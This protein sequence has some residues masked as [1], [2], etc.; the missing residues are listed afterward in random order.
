MAL[1][2]LDQAIY[3]LDRQIEIEVFIRGVPLASGLSDVPDTPNLLG[4]SIGFDTEQLPPT[5]TLTV[6][7]IAIHH[8]QIERGD[9]VEINAGFNG[10]LE[11]IFTGHV[12]R[13]TH[14]VANDTIECV[15]RTAVLTRPWRSPDDPKSW[16]AQTAVSAIEDILDDLTPAFAPAEI[17]D[18]VWGTAA[19]VAHG[20]TTD[21]FTIGYVVP[22]RMDSAAPS[23]MI[24]KI[25]DV[26]GYRV[27]E[28]KSGTLRIRPLLE[29]P[30]PAGYRIYG[31]QGVGEIANATISFDDA[32]IDSNPVLGN[33]AANARRAQGFTP[34]ADGNAIRMT[35][36][37]RKVGAPTDR[38]W[39]RIEEDDGAGEPNG[40]VLGGGDTI[41]GSILA[42]GSST[43][44]DIV[45]TTETRLV[46]GRVYHLVV[47]RGGGLDAVNYYEVGADTSAGYAGGIANVY[48]S[49]GGTWGA[50]GGDLA[51]EIEHVV[52][53]TL[54]LLGIADDED[55]DQI[56]KEVI[57]RGA[58]VPST[59]PASGDD[60]GGDE[61]QVQ[62]TA[63][64]HTD[65]NDLVEGD[66][67]L[68]SMVYTN[69]LIETVE[70]ADEVAARLIDKYHRVLQ[71]IE[72][73]VPFD[74][75]IDLGSTVEIRDQGTAPNYAGEVTG[76][77][78]NWWV[79]SYQ[80]SL[81]PDGATTSISLYGG[82]QSGSASE[83]N[84]QA[85][86]YWLIEREL[87][88]NAVQAVVTFFD[89][90]IDADGWIVNYHWVDDYLGGATDEEGESLR[91]ITIAYNPGTDASINM[92]LTVT[93]N[94]GNTH[95]VTKSVDVSTNN[96]EIYTPT[97]V[98]AGG[99]TCMATFD[100]G[101]S[102]AD[103]ATPSGV[104][105]KCAVGYNNEP[106]DP[107]VCFYG[108]DDGHIYRSIDSMASLVEVVG[109]ALTTNASGVGEI[110][111]IRSNRFTP[112]R[113]WACCDNGRILRSDDFG[114]T[115]Y[116][117]HDLIF[118]PG[119][120]SGYTAG[121]R[122][123]APDPELVAAGSTAAH[124]VT[125]TP[126]MGIEVSDPDVNRIWIWGGRGNE[127]E[128]WFHTHYLRDHPALWHSEIADVA[129]G[130]AADGSVASSTGNIAD[131]VADIVVSHRTAG[132]L[133]LCFTGRNPVFMYAKPKYYPATQGEWA[134][135]GGTPAVDGVS[136]AGNNA[137]MHLFG[138]VMDNKNFYRSQEGYGVWEELVGVLPGTGANRPHDLLNISAWK[139]IYI[140]AMD[141]GIAKSIDYGETWAFFRGA[142][143]GDIVAWPGGGGDI[144]YDCDIIYRRP[145]RFDIM[146]IVRDASG[147][148]AGNNLAVR[149]GLGGWADQ[150]A[151][152]T[153]YSTDPHR[154]W[155]FPQIDDQTLFF[156]RYTSALVG[157][158]E[159]LYRSTD[160]GGAWANVL[161]RCGT[162][163]RGPDG[164]IWASWESHAAGHAAGKHFP[165]VIAYSD[166]D[167]ATWTDAYT[168]PRNSGGNNISYFNIAVDPN[169]NRRVMAAGHLIANNLRILVTE[170][171]HLG[172]GATWSEV[173]P[174]GLGTYEG[175]SAVP[176]HHQPL[177]LAGENGRWLAGVQS[178]AAQQ[179]EIW[180][181]DNNG[182]TWTKTY[183]D[184]SLGNT[185]GFSDAFRMGNILFFGGSMVGA[186]VRS[187]G[188]VSFNNGAD[189]EALTA[190]AERQQG[191]VFDP[192]FSLLIGNQDTTGDNRLKFMLPPRPGYQ[193]N[194]GI[195]GGLDA[196]MPWATAVLVGN[197]LAVQGTV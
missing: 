37:L 14:D 165:H 194:S 64:R 67:R 8:V 78:G 32:N 21:D 61:T 5:A 103:I 157:H 41:A 185:W 175:A 140:V 60:P 36:W 110:T 197:A 88:G 85:D 2:P 72:I 179:R 121:S 99:T 190:D 45:V 138:M 158:S 130:D 22:A 124:L 20:D 131:T 127:P 101:V 50:G 28:Q 133:G 82:D 38:V 193:W 147:G 44:V 139:D 4:V 54:R 132:D 115:W 3:A 151:I 117:Y 129:H 150:G 46:S 109:P 113:W 123:H 24:R 125:P 81:T 98:C 71:S 87:V 134:D 42:V 171:A 154:L 107:P 178:A 74:P 114:A 195:A 29:A 59:T 156:V 118:G 89:A 31:T 170:D 62:I 180:I 160:L 128:S 58:T 102:W 12:K 97:L 192:R 80:H 116:V 40:T 23:D 30:A 120:P 122:R 34:T 18:I 191:F 47:G 73:E 95:S 112:A 10:H 164:R 94:D 146:A 105:K 142:G 183:T 177:L 16:T 27:Y 51:F 63:Q 161:A 136:V 153:G 68:Y 6:A 188:L 184:S 77:L 93:D 172:A 96:E 9:T 17:D 56:K 149:Q 168:D 65:S 163:T 174:T 76:L 25:A 13:R 181:S 57:V 33:V 169:N 35:F 144:G 137:K 52:F 106:D 186:A 166:D 108:T 145:R 26:Y 90:S 92:T 79:R 100:G 48:D 7:D 70:T 43:Q 15:G 196:A 11:R 176:K 104:A 1:G 75:R 111:G 119:Y 143:G 167:G 84:P 182:S 189:W 135:I 126:V 173:S 187:F 69:D 141:E 159:N 66:Y 86:F 55:E 49:G 53:P 39:F 152:P 91:E 162:I 148:A 83:A 19:R 155:H